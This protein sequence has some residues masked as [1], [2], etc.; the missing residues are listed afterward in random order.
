MTHFF[1]SRFA[2]Y[3]SYI[4]HRRAVRSASVSRSSAVLSMGT[5]S[6]ARGLTAGGGTAAGATTGSSPPGFS[7]SAMANSVT[8]SAPPSPLATSLA[9]PSISSF[10]LSSGAAVASFRKIV[11]PSQ[12]VSARERCAG[13]CPRFRAPNLGW[14]PLPGA[15]FRRMDLRDQGRLRAPRPRPR[16]ATRSPLSARSRRSPP[17]VLHGLPARVRCSRNPFQRRRF[18]RRW[19]LLPFPGWSGRVRRRFPVARMVEDQHLGR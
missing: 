2:L 14:S 9:G 6:S 5:S 1:P 7:S 12:V 13:T 17:R 16:S 3:I 19:K 4:A 10:R 15:V 11:L 18:S 8:S